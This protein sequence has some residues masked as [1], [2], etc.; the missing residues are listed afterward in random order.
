MNKTKEAK[1][2]G[3]AKKQRRYIERSGEIEA[4]IG[5]IIR[6]FMKNER[7]RAVGEYSSRSFRIEGIPS[8]KAT[9]KAGVDPRTEGGWYPDAP[10]PVWLPPAAFIKDG[11]QNQRLRDIGFPDESE[12]K[13]LMREAG[14]EPGTEEFE[15]AHRE[16]YEEWKSMYSEALTGELKESIELKA[17]NSPDEDPL[18]IPVTWRE[19]QEG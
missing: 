5:E 3:K 8:R 16:S 7:A 9:L 1:L 13:R 14:Y 2:H 12:N 17:S 11:R 19:D 6:H 15:E 18:E 4:G 10:H